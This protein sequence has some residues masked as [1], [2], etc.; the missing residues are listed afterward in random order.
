VRE[1]GIDLVLFSV[2]EAPPP[3]LLLQFPLPDTDQELASE[4][5]QDSEWALTP[6]VEKG[7]HG[8]LKG[9][10]EAIREVVPSAFQSDGKLAMP[11][12]FNVCANDRMRSAMFDCYGKLL[13]QL[14]RVIGRVHGSGGKPVPMLLA[15]LPEDYEGTTE[16]NGAMMKEI[17]RQSGV[18][19]LNVAPFLT[20]TSSSLYMSHGI[21]GGHLIKF[22]F[23]MYADIL[24]DALVQSGAVK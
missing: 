2:F 12:F 18:P 9:L 4:P 21:G 3:Y 24:A 7:S 8:A 5:K 16:C 19:L 14:H 22:G 23:Y 6:D 20:A 15:Y 17:S 1:Y 13:T 10:F 11:E